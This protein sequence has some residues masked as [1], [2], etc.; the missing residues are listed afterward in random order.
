MTIST[1]EPVGSHISLWGEGPLWH[2][3]RL[4]YVDI[5]GHK[6]LS[7]DPVTNQEKI[8]DVG[9]RVGCVVARQGGGLAWAGEHGFSFLDEATGVSTPIA[10]PEADM[11][12]NR[13]NDGK[14]DPAG[15]F[16]AGTIP[17]THRRPEA[18]LYCMEAD[19]SV[20]KKFSPVTVSNGLVWTRDTRTLFYIDSPRK[21]VLAFDFDVATG[22]ISNQRI[23]FDLSGFVGTP[24]GMAIDVGDRIWI[25][26]CHGSSIRAFDTRTWKCEAEIAM[27]CREVTACAFGGPALT[28]LYITTGIPKD[29][30]EPLAGRLFIAQPGVTG[31]ASHTF[32]G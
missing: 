11:P 2:R 24:D 6:I 21:N 8:W 31:A 30:V 32:A 1:P 18:A 17:L 7:F 20:S 15:R 12:G 9:Q 14:C 25:A 4:L 23:A 10:D 27:P 22:A 13:F 16:W 5:E 19:H 29:N 3:D 26:F 28:D